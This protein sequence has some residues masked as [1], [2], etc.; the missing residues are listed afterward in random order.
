MKI[1]RIS[2][3]KHKYLQITES[4]AKKPEILFFMG[5][6]PPERIPSVAIVGTRKPTAYGKEVGHY[7][8]YQLAKRGVVIISGLALGIDAIAHRGALEAGGTTLAILGN[9]LPGI[10]P[11]SHK[12]LAKEIIEKNGAILPSM[13]PKPVLASITF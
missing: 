13:N 5:K 12:T 7:L 4:I 6:L 11:S 3:D 1:N 2:P 8:A 10:Y 9:G